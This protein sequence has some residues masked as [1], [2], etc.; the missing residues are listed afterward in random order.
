M[1]ENN[2]DVKISRRNNGY[3]VYAHNNESYA[4]IFIE[5]EDAINFTEWLFN[6]SG[7]FP[8]DYFTEGRK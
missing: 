3:I 8:G 4:Y 7:K 2:Y 1:S 5:L 6:N